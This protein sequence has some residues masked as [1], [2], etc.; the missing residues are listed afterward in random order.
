MNKA[1]LR[2]IGFARTKYKTLE[3]CPR[4]GGEDCPP[5]EIEIE[6]AFKE[7][8][9]RMYLGQNITVLTWLYQANRRVLQCKPRGDETL[10]LHGI[11][12]TRSPHRPNPLGLHPVQ[13]TDIRENKITVQQL[14]V[15][16]GTPIIDIKPDVLPYTR[17]ADPGS[18]FP[19]QDIEDLMQAGKQLWQRGLL[20]GANGNLSLRRGAN[21]LITRSGA[22]KGKMSSADLTV[23][24]MIKGDIISGE[25]PSSEYGMH[26]AIYRNRPGAK[27]IVHTHPPQILALQLQGKEGELFSLPLYEA[28]LFSRQLDTV[29]SIPPG[30]EELAREA[31]KKSKKGKY[32]ILKG[33]GLIT[34]GANI[35]EAASASEELETLAGIALMHQN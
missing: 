1:S 27:A 3:D 25:A 24:D 28:G 22:A 17:S 7:G 12:C 35:S 30:S 5:A 8:M 9:H 6:P 19:S 33:H 34:C 13:I 26:L 20:S 18:Y 10:P 15:L 16:D 4:Q 14:E 2:Y 29:P 23:V 21:M 31:G 32:L 11:F